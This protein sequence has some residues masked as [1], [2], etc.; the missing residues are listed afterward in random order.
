MMHKESGKLTEWFLITTTK[1]L[2]VSQKELKELLL[3]FIVL[4]LKVI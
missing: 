3:K 1:P 2:G 4:P